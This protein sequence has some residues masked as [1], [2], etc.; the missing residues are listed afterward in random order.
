MD[1]INPGNQ[2]V[3]ARVPKGTTGD[4]D[5][6][7]VS[8]RNTFESGVWSRI[9]VEERAQVMMRAV[10]LV[11]ANKERLAYLESLTSGATI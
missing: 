4:V 10:G 9:S 1:V 3:V 11:V 5:K 2:E 8:A 6:A 7:V